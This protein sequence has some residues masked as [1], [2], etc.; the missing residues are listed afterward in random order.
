[1]PAFRIRRVHDDVLPSNQDAI[2]QVQEILAGRFTAV[3]PQD[4]DQLAEKLHNPF[5]QQF[6]SILYV[7]SNARQQVFGFALMM[8]EPRLG[9]C[10]LDYIAAA[11][12]EAGGGVGGALYD[13]VRREAK[14]L[15]AEGLFFECLPDDPE[16]CPDPQLRKQN[17]ARLKFYER[18]GAYPVAGTAYQTPINPG[19]S[20]MPLLVYDALDGARPLARRFAQKV[21][22]AILERKYSHVC[23]PSYVETVVA[24]FR[25]DPV[26]LRPPRYVRSPRSRPSETRLEGDERIGLLVNA[27]H[28]IHHVHDRGYVE[29]PV[30]VQS[31]LDGIMPTGWFHVLRPKTFP[32]A[33][34]QTVHD[35][36]FVRYLGRACG[37]VP[38]G[39]SLYPY[40][41]PIRNA[42]RPPKDL[43]VRAG[44]YCIDTFTPLSRNAF[45]AAKRAVDCALT[46]T[47]ELLRGRRAVYCLVRPPGHHAERR[48]FG[49]FCYFNSAAIAAQRLSQYG[50]V[51][52]VDV[53]F[54]HG[55]GQQDIFYHRDD[56]LTVS[57]H[58]H[59]NFVY[60]YFSGFADERGE[61]PGEGCCV[62]FPLAEKIDVALYHRTLEKALRRAA[63]F[64]PAALVIA[65]GF[66]TARADPTGT[67]PLRAKDF[68]TNGRM[69]GRMDVPTLIVQEGGYRVRTLG[70]NARSFFEGLVAGMMSR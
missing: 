42:A 18:F 59:P 56:V 24:S 68:L 70:A 19:D 37:A 11:P 58:G 38:A 1:M 61:G 7:A 17:E 27:R 64:Q 10:F 29:A 20:N 46:G 47:E 60:P 32:R 22:R 21:V 52:V 43:T 65:L 39:K 66:D 69:I 36:D 40:V 13:R 53:D 5:K 26:R 62:N 67:W 33:V 45:L 9:F 35:A 4:I 14:V 41:F 16:Q 28:D 3:R 49:G 55:N 25:D 30:R 57:V 6:R 8:H 2:R 12:G 54:H 48:S 63:D 31:I 51:A 50:R 44:Y 34:L 23:P 15:G